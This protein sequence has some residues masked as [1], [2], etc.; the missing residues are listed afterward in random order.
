MSLPNKGWAWTDQRED[1]Q[2]MVLHD[3][4]DDPNLVEVP[5]Q[6]PHLPHHCDRLHM[7]TERQE[8]QSLSQIGTESAQQRDRRNNGTGNEESAAD[9]VQRYEQ[10]GVSCLVEVTYTPVRP[11]PT[12]ASQRGC[13]PCGY[14][15]F[16]PNQAPLCFLSNDVAL[17]WA[18]AAHPARPS[19]PKGSLN[20]IVTDETHWR[21]QSAEIARLAN[22]SEWVSANEREFRWVPLIL[23]HLPAHPKKEATYGSF[24]VSPAIR[25]PFY[26][27]A[28][29][30]Q[31]RV[32]EL[33]NASV[34]VRFSAQPMYS[35]VTAIMIRHAPTAFD[36]TNVNC[37]TVLQHAPVLQRGMHL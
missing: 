6:Y 2:Q 28:S 27:S 34:R 19:T 21:F 13:A 4:A 3:V 33:S 20:V 14:A 24:F 37:G 9:T 16:R 17:L 8:P 7:R 36:A 10:V 22:L 15:Y 30:H 25:S 26:W 23:Q 11:K 31:A 5:A 35:L 29:K 18:Q 32:A 12:R 1:L